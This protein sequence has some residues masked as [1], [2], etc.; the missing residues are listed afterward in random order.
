MAKATT[1]AEY[2]AGLSDDRRPVVEAMRQHVLRH[3]PPGYEE[4]MSA[5]M[6]AW[7][8]PLARLPKTYNGQP[9][10]YA[11]LASEKSYCSLHLMRAYGDPGQTAM[12]KAAFA[13]AGKKL[14]MGKACVHFTRLEDLQLDAIGAVLA[15]TPVDAFVAMYQKSRKTS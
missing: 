7:V 13:R 12:L 4:T 5:G 2:L 11:A 8:V 1:V 10:W 14:D 3:L 15:S 9:L 6:I